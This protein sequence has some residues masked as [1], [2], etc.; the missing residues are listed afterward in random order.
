MRKF[1]QKKNKIL[2]KTASL[3][4]LKKETPFDKFL[5]TS[6]RVL[7]LLALFLAGFLAAKLQNLY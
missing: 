4:H 1:F 6:L 3:L 2:D 5:K 7:M